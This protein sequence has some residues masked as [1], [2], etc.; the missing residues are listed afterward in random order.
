MG[1]SIEGI[2]ED[3]IE[4]S[5]IEGICVKHA[6]SRER[7]FAQKRRDWAI[8]ERF[9]RCHDHNRMRVLLISLLRG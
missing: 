5:F 6:R 8:L 9:L 4:E 7:A 2:C 1:V 3:S